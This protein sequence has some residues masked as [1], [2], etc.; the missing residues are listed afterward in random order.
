MEFTSMEN[1]WNEVKECFDLINAGEMLD[2]DQIEVVKEF[3]REMNLLFSFFNENLGKQIFG[4]RCRKVD[5]KI[6][7]DETGD[8]VTMRGI[9]GALWT[10]PVEWTPVVGE[11][12]HIAPFD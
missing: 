7:F 1:K 3:M 11:K 12:K 6:V 10:R 9:F 8:L 5:G 2:M 4:R